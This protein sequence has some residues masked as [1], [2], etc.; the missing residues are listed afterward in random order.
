MRPLTGIAD[1]IVQTETNTK[2]S[3]LST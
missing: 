3:L 2:S 1:P